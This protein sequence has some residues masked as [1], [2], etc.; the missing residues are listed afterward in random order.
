MTSCFNSIDLLWFDALCEVQMRTPRES[1]I[2]QMKEVL[3]WQ[4]MLC[5]I[6]RTFLQSPRRRLSPEYACAELLWYLSGEAK[7]DMI[8]AYAPQ[9]T[10]YANDGIA[11]G[12]YGYRMRGQLIDGLFRELR[13]HSNSRRAVIA[14]WN[15]SDIHA[16]VQGTSKDIPCTLTWQFLV[17]DNRLHMICTMRSQD[18]WLGMPYDVF[19]NTCYQRLIADALGFEYGS[20]THQCGSLHLYE[21]NWEA[22]LEC[23]RNFNEETSGHDW[24]PAE[25]SVN[26]AAH[27]VKEEKRIRETGYGYLT[28]HLQGTLLDDA[29]RICMAKW[30]K[31][32]P[33]IHSPILKEAW[34]AY[35][36][37]D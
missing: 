17:R 7:I 2:G 9:Y 3:G 10:N 22:A 37:R 33:V 29:L 25:N 11:N 31:E 13:E 27:A 12:S 24:A 32:T 28:H 34:R 23:D 19:V 14:M 20:Y 36:R 5:N 26:Q 18:I 15:E 30:I 1:R 8:A 6:D 35:N 4:G 21:K 16:S